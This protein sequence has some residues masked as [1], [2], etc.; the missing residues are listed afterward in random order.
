[1]R[2]QFPA[3]VQ[4]AIA[5]GDASLPRGFRNNNPFN[6]RKSAVKW[7][8]KTGNDGA[9]EIFATM[10]AGLAAGIVNVRTKVRR[11]AD[12]IEK[13]IN[14][15]SPPVENDTAGYIS[16][17]AAAARIGAADVVDWNNKPLLA[18]IFAEMVKIENGRHLKPLDLISKV[19]AKNAI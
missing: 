13:F 4:A 5:S 9:F 11:G 3:A 17:V 2:N 19:I 1:M 14:I 8:G 7:R 15:L 12:T 16:Q 6:V 18:R 10:E